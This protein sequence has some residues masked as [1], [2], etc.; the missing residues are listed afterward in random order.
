M[1]SGFKWEASVTPLLPFVLACLAVG[2]VRT[3]VADA[4][5]AGPPDLMAILQQQAAQMG[6]NPNM[7]L[8]P[9]VSIV[10]AI[11]VDAQTDINNLITDFKGLFKGVLQPL[12]K[13]LGTLPPAAIQAILL[14]LS[15]ASSL[16]QMLQIIENALPPTPPGG[17]SLGQLISDLTDLFNKLLSSL[18]DPQP[19]PGSQAPIQKVDPTE[20]FLD[21]LQPVLAVL[22][23]I[24]DEL[25][26]GCSIRIEPEQIR[27]TTG[28]ATVELKGGD[29]E[30]KAQGSIKIEGES[31]SISPSPCKC[32]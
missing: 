10:A 19:A 8:P 1:T 22:A 21:K 13:L 23:E 30:I 12:L 5:P 26:P 27:I 32:G 2:V 16:Q 28:K 20:Q 18:P 3:K 29:I 17:T 25:S 11:P 15:Q 9:G 14:S 31:V 4:F 7:G 6:W 24:M